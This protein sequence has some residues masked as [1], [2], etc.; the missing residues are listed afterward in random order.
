MAQR[1]HFECVALLGCLPGSHNE[2]RARAVSY[3]HPGHAPYDMRP[4]VIVGVPAQREP[5]A[6]DQPDAPPAWATPT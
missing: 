1:V 4:A 2:G 3:R 5:G 6:P